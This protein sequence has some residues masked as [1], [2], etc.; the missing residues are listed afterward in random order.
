MTPTSP[1]EALAEGALTQLTAQRPSA[2]SSQ[3]ASDC[4][5]LERRDT[6]NG[7]NGMHPQDN[8]ADINSPQE[9]AAFQLTSL[10]NV[11]AD[12]LLNGNGHQ[13]P[14][15]PV[16]SLIPSPR[17]PPSPRSPILMNGCHTPPSDTQR[18][19]NQQLQVLKD[20]NSDSLTLEHVNDP[21][22]EEGKENAPA[23]NG[24]SSPASTPKQDP[25]RRHSR[26]PVFEPSSILD[27]PHG[28]AKEKLLQRRVHHFPLSPSASPSLSSD[29]RA[30]MIAMQR[31][32]IS[33][34]SSERSQDDESLMGSRSD[35]HGDDALSLSSSSSPLLR[36]SKIP[37]PV[38]PTSSMET[39][40]GQFMP[41]PPP[42]KP[43]S[44]S[45]VDGRLRRYRIRAGSTSDSDLLTCL[46]QLMHASSTHG[47]PQHSSSSPQHVSARHVFHHL[48]QRSSSASPRSSSSLQRSVSSSPSRHEHRGGCLG[49]SRSPPSFSGSPPQRRSHPHAQDGCCARQARSITIHTQRGKAAVRCSSKLSR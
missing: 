42:G 12:P 35:R 24:H 44:R 32:Q 16:P 25:S 13:K 30:I 49:R 1:G 31:D 8:T 4:G 17:T 14:S 6:D 5:S 28:S 15:S 41:R 46:A 2:M 3:C 27:P 36:K 43:P 9:Q 37:R 7:N 38:T 40:T 47:S 22:L 21:T 39:L 34:A 18:N 19:G 20:L 48:H 26:I 33:S 23:T 10:V 45:N 29:R 11:E